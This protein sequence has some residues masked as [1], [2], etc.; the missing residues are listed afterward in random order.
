MARTHMPTRGTNGL[1]QYPSLRF[2]AVPNQSPIRHLL[3]AGSHS[4]MLF[5]CD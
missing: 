1:F 2:G 4:N 3:Q 5:P